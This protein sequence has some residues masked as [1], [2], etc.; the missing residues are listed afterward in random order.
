MPADTAMKK[1]LII[2]LCIFTIHSAFPVLPVG[3]EELIATNKNRIQNFY[4]IYKSRL[5]STWFSL[6]LRH[7]ASL[8]KSGK[9]RY[10]SNAAEKI[11]ALLR[12]SP[13]RR[14]L[15]I[16]LKFNGKT[17]L[18]NNLKKRKTAQKQLLEAADI[19]SG[20]GITLEAGNCFQILGDSESREGKFKRAE[21]S[22]LSAYTSFR[23]GSHWKK[24]AHTA[25]TMGRNA[26][27][28]GKRKNAGDFF[29]LTVS[30]AIQIKSGHLNA[31]GQEGLGDLALYNHLY[32]KAQQHYER[33]IRLEGTDISD[34]KLGY[35][36]QKIGRALKQ[37][38]KFSDA[39]VFFQK[40]LICF[41]R[42]NIRNM[43]IRLTLDLASSL[44]LASKNREA[45]QTYTYGLRTLSGIKN[46]SLKGYFHLS[47]GKFKYWQ[48]K[49]D[50]AGKHLRIAGRIFKAAGNRLGTANVSSATANLA[51]TLGRRRWRKSLLTRALRIYR[52]YNYMAS[53]A[54]TLYNLADI[55]ISSSRYTTAR[56]YLQEAGNIYE[57]N[58]APLGRA[59]VLQSLAFIAYQESKYNLAFRLAEKTE[60]LNRISGT[61][62]NMANAISLKGLIRQYQRRYREAILFLKQADQIYTDINIPH[63]RLQPLEA[64]F[65][66]FRNLNRKQ[67]AR[68]ALNNYLQLIL[69]LRA[70]SGSGKRRRYI[71]ETTGSSLK[72]MIILAASSDPAFA[73]KTLERFRGRT[74]LES[75][76]GRSA[77][78]TAGIPENKIRKWLTLQQNLASARI[79]LQKITGPRNTK[80]RARKRAARKKIRKARNAVEAFE[81]QLSNGYPRYAALR[82]PAIPNPEKTRSLLKKN[83][84]MLVFILNRN[85]LGRW[86]LGRNKKTV[87]RY[88]ILPG[89]FTAILKKFSKNTAARKYSAHNS[90]LIRKTLFLGLQ[91]N[92]LKSGRI[93]II[94][95][96]QLALLPW[97]SLLSGKKTGA[98]HLSLIPSLSIFTALRSSETANRTVPP[99]PVLVFGGARYR[100]NPDRK[101]EKKL[102]PEERLTMLN[103]TRTGRSR[104][105]NW[106]NLPGSE[107]EGK[108]ICRIWYPDQPDRQL[109]AFFSGIFAS[110]EAVKAINRGLKFGRERLSL[111]DARI[112]HFAVHG[113]AD[114][115]NDATSRLILSRKKALSPGERKLLRKWFPDFPGEDGN[116]NAG[117]ILGLKVQADLVVLS[118]CQTGIGKMT[119]TEGILGLTR[120]WFIAGARGVLVSLWNVSD[121]GTRVFMT[122]FHKHLAEGDTPAEALKKVCASLQNGSWRKGEFAPERTFSI[123]GHAISWKQLDLSSPYYWAAFQYWGR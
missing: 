45:Q 20:F 41:R 93:N 113:K 67:E 1:S 26:L 120:S 35:L 92:K 102:T 63:N 70:S 117:E 65:Y 108:S 111:A 2:L 22:Y 95:D 40:A 60:Q 89:G 21:R 83:E 123:R 119:D 29:R 12:L 78:K 50:L 104:D 15:A 99:L 18:Q 59:N 10:A 9:H 105:E 39:S 62:N 54:D 28:S 88:S 31:L 86:T 47:Y 58:N 30:H 69:R 103:A 43:V 56:K 118:A 96:G 73:L 19:F 91:L 8:D 61:R 87:F 55:A 114:T 74:F 82:H 81:K 76:Q 110:E 106:N 79:L 4:N 32:E 48:G 77:L 46:S 72:A 90:R 33:A 23:S 17:I 27:N 122:I 51:R 36:F 37:G 53:I 7:L 84:T 49:Y 3:L 116:L 64:L 112:L 115:R 80:T 75:L 25:Y 121:I 94:P 5:S 13:R 97:N 68:N 71:Q 107:K 6:S 109:A 66:C 101:T 98:A 14:Q 34:K 57:K 52:K 38:A 42:A 11:I 85:R 44:R 24:A 100:E 16:F